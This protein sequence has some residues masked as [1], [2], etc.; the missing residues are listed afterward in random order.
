MISEAAR[1]LVVTALTRRLR[2]IDV[3]ESGELCVAPVDPE[4]GLR[5][6]MVRYLP[7]AAELQTEQQRLRV[8]ERLIGIPNSGTAIAS[9]TVEIIAS[10]A[11]T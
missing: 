8:C 11:L 1:P 5:D 10:C 7:R 9:L 6:V 2:E 3:R 4:E